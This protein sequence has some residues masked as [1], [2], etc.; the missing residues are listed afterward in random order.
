MAWCQGP[1]DGRHHPPDAASALRAPE[2]NPVGN[3]RACLRANRRAIFVFE[4]CGDIVA[5]CC[6]AR[7]FFANDIAKVRSTVA[8]EYA[9]AVRV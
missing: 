1:E 7:T 6:D 9:K 8:R 5:R 3:A 4:T 2:I